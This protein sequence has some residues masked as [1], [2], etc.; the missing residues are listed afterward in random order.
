MIPRTLGQF[1]EAARRHGFAADTLAY[2]IAIGCPIC[3]NG[4]EVIFDNKLGIVLGLCNCCGS[5]SRAMAFAFAEL[6]RRVER[7]SA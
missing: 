5:S 2:G 4:Q 1:V 3:S 6:D 7:R